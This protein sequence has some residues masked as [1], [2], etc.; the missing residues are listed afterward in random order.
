VGGGRDQYDIYVRELSRQSAYGY[1]YP[2]NTVATTSTSYLEID[3]NSTDS[4]YASKEKDGLHTTIAHE[5]FHAVQ[6][7]YYSLFD[8]QWWQETTAVWMEDVAY[9]E[10]N[11]YYQYLSSFFNAPTT[12]LDRFLPFGD[13]HPFGS[14]VF[15]H[16]LHALFGVAPIRAGW[17]NLG[18]KKITISVFLMLWL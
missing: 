14:V 10:V 7:G 15:V 4:I 1:T 9:T 18:V 16:N 5:F 8:A 2:E 17:E 11:D 13:L 6:F 3:N 12:S